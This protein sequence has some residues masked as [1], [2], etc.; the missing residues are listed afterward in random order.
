MGGP[1]HAAVVTGAAALRCFAAAVAHCRPASISYAEF[2][3]DTGVDVVATVEP[4]EPCRALYVWDHYTA[5]FD[6]STS[7]TTSTDCSVTENSAR[8][9]FQCPG[10]YDEIPTT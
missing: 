2:G 6:G 5:N 1:N 9:R 10:L 8:V 4:G 3:V 7:P